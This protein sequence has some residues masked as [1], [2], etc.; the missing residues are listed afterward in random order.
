MT[1]YLGLE[2]F[3]E[4][5]EDATGVDRESISLTAQLSLAESALAAPQAAFGGTE[6]YP[7]FVDKAAVLCAHLAWNHALMDGNKRTAWLCLDRFCEINGYELRPGSVDD[8]VALM[9]RLAAH[10]TDERQLAEWIRTHLIT[11]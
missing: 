2:D 7:D 3:L 1:S 4:L 11:R 6:F 9:V 10:E 5:A 8:A